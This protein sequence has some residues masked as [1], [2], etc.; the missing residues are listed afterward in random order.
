MGQSMAAPRSKEARLFYRCAYQ[1]LEEA[2]FLLGN[3]M[4]TAAVYLGGYSIECMLKALILDNV[5]A[6]KRR[7]VLE[8]FRGRVAHDFRWL[9][10]QYYAAGGALPPREVVLQ[11]NVAN[12]WSTD[13][14]YE[15]RPIES[16]DAASFVAAAD[17]ILRW[18]QG[19]L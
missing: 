16:A 14:R 12:A 17:G 4:N 2:K 15:P 11:L 18:A 6:S 8:G 3:Q 10:Q 19:R 1:R 9:R 13:L 7:A 5:S